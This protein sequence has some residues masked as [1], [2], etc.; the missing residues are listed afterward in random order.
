MLADNIRAPRQGLDGQDAALQFKLVDAAR[1]ERIVELVEAV[2][3]GCIGN[4]MVSFFFHVQCI[5]RTCVVASGA[6]TSFFIIRP[7]EFTL[8]SAP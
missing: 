3:Q 5:A 2:H 8:T 7:L 4:G 1:L 6:M